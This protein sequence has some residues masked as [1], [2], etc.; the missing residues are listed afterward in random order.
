MTTAA[1]ERHFSLIRGTLSRMQDEQAA[2]RARQQQIQE[3][4]GNLTEQ[5]TAFRTDFRE[6]SSDYYEFR[7]SAHQPAPAPPI[8]R[9]PARMG[10]SRRRTRQR[11]DDP[12]AERPEYTG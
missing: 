6:F 11:T 2:S 5:F 1:L 10:Y 12:D 8:E 3:S 9:L 7:R 4:V